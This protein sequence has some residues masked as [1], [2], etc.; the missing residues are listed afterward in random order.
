[1]WI[2]LHSILFSAVLIVAVAVTVMVPFPVVLIYTGQWQ[3]TPTLVPIFNS[4]CGRLCTLPS[5]CLVTK[6]AS[7]ILNDSIIA[8]FSFFHAYVGLLYKTFYGR[9]KFRIFVS[10]NNIQHNDTQYNDSQNNK[11]S[12]ELRITTLSIMKLNVII[13]S[14]PT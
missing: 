4:R 7:L 2:N 5:F 10:R 12:H 1:M 6:L 13:I 8:T 11:L 9:N 14:I 3:I